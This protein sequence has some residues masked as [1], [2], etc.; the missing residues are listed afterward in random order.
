M[1]A[2]FSEQ[3][4]CRT[5]KVSG[6]VGLV[7]LVRIVRA[8]RV[9][10]DIFQLFRRHAE[11]CIGIVKIDPEQLCCGRLLQRRERIEV[12]EARHNSFMV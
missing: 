7:H 8:V 12:K 11:V 5:N 9:R 2:A 4:G 6:D 3:G 10:H 1:R